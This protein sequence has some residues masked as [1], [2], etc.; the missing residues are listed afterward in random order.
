M[1]GHGDVTEDAAKHILALFLRHSSRPGDLLP[2]RDL[3][4]AFETVPWR[5]ADLPPGIDFAV[6]EGWI[7]QTVNENRTEISTAYRSDR[8]DKEASLG[9][10][11]PLIVAADR[12]EAN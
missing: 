1:I 10:R 2:P 8:L 9:Y 6:G 3:S 4:R 11:D 5:D 12:R 7:E